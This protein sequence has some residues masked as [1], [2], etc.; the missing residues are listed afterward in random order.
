MAPTLMVTC[1]QQ[2]CL[3][4]DTRRPQRAFTG[5]LLV[6]ILLL[7][8]AWYISASPHTSSAAGLDV[9]WQQLPVLAPGLAALYTF[10]CIDIIYV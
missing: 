4:A 1:Q 9:V 6:A 5:L 3:L 7:L 8:K 2:L 10:C